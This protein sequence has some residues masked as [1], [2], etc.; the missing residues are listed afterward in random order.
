MFFDWTLLQEHNF[1]KNVVP[2]VREMAKNMKTE[3]R[4]SLSAMWSLLALFLIATIAIAV[5]IIAL[6]HRSRARRY[7]ERGVVSLQ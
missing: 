4:S 3:T 2:Y 7:P 1:W 6:V 5:L